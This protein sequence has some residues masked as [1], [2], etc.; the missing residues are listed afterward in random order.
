MIKKHP[1][2]D[3]SNDQQK[4]DDSV[5]STVG[6]DVMNHGESMA[7]EGSGN[8]P[9]DAGRSLEQ[10]HAPHGHKTLPEPAAASQRA[11]DDGDPDTIPQRLKGRSGK[12]RKASKTVPGNS[13]TDDQTALV[14]S[15]ADSPPNCR[16]NPPPGTISQNDIENVGKS[17]KRRFPQRSCYATLLHNPAPQSSKNCENST[18]CRRDGCYTKLLHKLP[19]GMCVRGNNFYVRRRVP[20]DVESAVGRVEIWRSLQTDSL[21]TALRR[22]PLVV[23][24]IETIIAQ[25]RFDAGISIDA[26]LLDPPIGREASLVSRPILPIAGSFHAALD[27]DHSAAPPRQ[28]ISGITFGEA[29]D[30]YI[31]DPTQ[32]WSD[33]TR[34]TYETCRKVAVSVIGEN[35]LIGDVSRTH[36][37]EFLEVLKFLPKNSAKRFPKL[38]PRD[39]ANMM[40]L[41]SAPTLISSANANAYLTSLSTFM[42]WSVNEELL[43]RNPARGLR[44]PDETAKR[45]KRHP[46]S[47]DQLKSI[48]HAPLYRG[49][50][51]GERGY[52]IPGPERPRNAR[53]WV[54]LIA[55]HS[56]MRLNEICQLDVSDIESIDGINCIAVRSESLVGSDDKRLKTG[57]SRRLIPIHRALV[58]LGFLAYVADQQ[59]GDQT[60]LF[61][62]I[63]P[64]P[65]GAR[66]VAFSKWFTQFLRRSGACRD[67]T[68]F[69]SFRHNFRDELRVA[70]IDHD[71]AMVLG[72]WTGGSSGRNKVSENYGHGHR[73]KMLS[74]AVDRLEF[75]DIDLSH[76]HR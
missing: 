69:H 47:A 35:T 58:E 19:K 53:F 30:R 22:F 56:G 31:N 39:A 9:A 63:E 5:A 59:R 62:E 42:N 14:K 71:I 49:C 60:K 52:A 68:C 18:G 45:D 29:Y 40:R 23:S 28:P 64:G 74:E 11:F 37:R 51:N 3:P 26:M 32:S 17:S 75:A 55:L 1:E 16:P 67:R 54:P 46:F 66:S 6:D 10:H 73:I 25:A 44:L 48:F 70:R 34:E 13:S 4:V 33:R 20:K 12:A 65:K 76:L 2:N 21:G 50:L 24:K 7:S 8:G 27:R 36:I 57:A 15:V 43:H 72:G 61:W 41:E 38:S